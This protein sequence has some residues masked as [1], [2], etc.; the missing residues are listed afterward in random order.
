MGVCPQP[1]ILRRGPWLP[2]RVHVGEEVREQFAYR[3]GVLP[4]LPFPGRIAALRH[5]GKS[6]PSE[7][8]RLL[9]RQGAM[10]PKVG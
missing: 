1:A 8:T 7:V 3:W 6:A 10:R 2:V 9:R 5:I 4:P